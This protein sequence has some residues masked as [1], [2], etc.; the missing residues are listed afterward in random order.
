M[1]IGI[2]ALWGCGFY[3]SFVWMEIFTTDLLQRDGYDDAI[4]EPAVINA[5][6]M[7]M[8]IM[9]QIPGGIASFWILTRANAFLCR[10]SPRPSHTHIS[11]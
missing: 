5:L 4:W 3:S 9:F 11:L 2:V 1:I 8:L 6:M 7:F 10:R